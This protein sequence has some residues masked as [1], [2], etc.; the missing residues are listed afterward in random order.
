MENRGVLAN[1]TLYDTIK[2]TDAIEWEHL[3]IRIRELQNAQRY[4][5][6]VIDCPV[7]KEILWNLSY[8]DKNILQ[9]NVDANDTDVDWVRKSMAIANRCGMYVVLY[10]GSI[11]PIHTP[12][13]KVLSILDQC[14]GYGKFHVVLNFFKMRPV[15]YS[16]VFSI[17]YKGSIIPKEYLCLHDQELSCSDTYTHKFLIGVQIYTTLRNIPV[18]IQDCTTRRIS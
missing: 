18:Y 16:D 3:A 11:M 2:A 14:K 4:L 10:L 5:R 7:P 1:S 9:I 17:N 12:L 13:L 6:L 15:E 8:S